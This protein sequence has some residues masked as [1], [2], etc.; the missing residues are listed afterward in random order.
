MDF[1]IIHDFDESL[2]NTNSSAEKL[3]EARQIILQIENTGTLAVSFKN[4]NLYLVRPKTKLILALSI[5]LGG[6]LGAATVLAHNA[7]KSRKPLGT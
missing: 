5:V 7:V 2:V 1:A 4:P 3:L 6:F